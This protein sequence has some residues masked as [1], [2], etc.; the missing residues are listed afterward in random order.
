MMRATPY[1]SVSP[2]AI[3]AYMPPRMSPVSRMSTASMPRALRCA[4][5][6]L[7]AFQAGFG[8]DRR[9][10]AGRLAGPMP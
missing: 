4:A 1:W 9:A 7:T 10:R 2:I 3:S 6:Q 8:N 5:A